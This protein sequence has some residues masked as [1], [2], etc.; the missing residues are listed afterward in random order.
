[1]RGATPP[2]P[3]VTS[4]HG[5]QLIA[6]TTYIFK[7]LQKLAG[8]IA[9]VTAVCGCLGEQLLQLRG[10]QSPTGSLQL[11]VFNWE[12]ATD[13]PTGSFQLE[14]SNWQ[15]PAGRLQ[16]TFSNWQSPTG[17]LQLTVSNLESSTGSLQLT[18][19]KLESPTGSLQRQ[20]LRGH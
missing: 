6:E 4:C 7:H 9:T 16:L 3:H 10:W 8:T 5:V 1:M 13:F 20:L 15:F 11:A 19:S 14:V 17:S 18:V 2:F 12:A